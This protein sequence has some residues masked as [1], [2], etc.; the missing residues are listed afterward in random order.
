MMMVMM[1]MIAIVTKYEQLKQQY[2][3]QI[4]RSL[5]AATVMVN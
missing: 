5:A 1:R 4:L 3:E 2:F